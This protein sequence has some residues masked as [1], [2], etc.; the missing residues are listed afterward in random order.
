MKVKSG[1]V[2]KHVA[3]KHIVV[4]VGEAAVNFSGL[5]TLN[6]SGVLLFEAMKKHVEIEDLMVILVNRYDVDSRTA[7]EDAE[8]FVNILKSKS[9]LE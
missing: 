4:P 7:R 8:A 9:I 3:G 5:I 6:E 1:F 2:L